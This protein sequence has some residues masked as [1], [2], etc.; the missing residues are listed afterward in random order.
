MSADVLVI[1][2]GMIVHDQILPSLYHL[3]RLGQIG[4]LNVVAT[5]SARLKEL[6]SPRFTDAFPGQQF[7]AYPALDRPENERRPDLW[8]EAIPRLAHQSLVVVATPDEAHDSMVRTALEHDQHV[9]CVKPL[10][11]RYDQAEAIGRLA[12]ER[13]LLVM[14]EYH[15]R[16]DRRSLE[17]RKLYRQGCYG[18][19]ACGQAC[20]IEH[21]YYRSS[22]FQHWFTTD[23]TDPFTYVGCHYV[24]LVYFITGLRPVEVSVRGV[25][26]KFPNGNSA[27]MWANGRVV[28]ENGAILSVNG[29]LG[30]PDRSA[31]SNDQ[32]ITMYCEGENCG[33]LIQHNDQFRGVGYGFVDDRFGAPF[34]HVNPDYF[35]LVPWTG[36]GLKPV[37]YG[38]D[39]IEAAVATTL[40]LRAIGDGHEAIVGRQA[41][42]AA[43]DEQGLLATPQ[44]SFINELVI[45]AARRSVQSNGDAVKIHY[46][47]QPGVES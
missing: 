30:Y 9:L 28:F 43:V 41:E 23:K 16:F 10:V 36:A 38:Y 8:L 5:S 42:L 19:F 21:Y 37:G 18:E 1:G 34:R 24:D 25:E 31:G 26:R 44:N 2:G 20:L 22:N 27:F 3:Q 29:G 6:V 13:G 40:R 7:M 39:S 4:Q 35:R 14:V 45:E 12:R 47:S 15:K 32:G 17:A 11:H 33:G 46:G